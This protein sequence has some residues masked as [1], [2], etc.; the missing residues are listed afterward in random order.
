MHSRGWLDVVAA[1]FSD[2]PDLMDILVTRPGPMALHIDLMALSL[3]PMALPIGL[4]GMRAPG[5]LLLLTDTRL[6]L[7]DPIDTDDTAIGL[8]DTL[9]RPIG[10][11]NRLDLL[12]L[13]NR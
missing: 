5:M 1:S 12:H 10:R 9:R 11:M 6:T 2:Y 7:T 8:T 13:P 3:G 4:M